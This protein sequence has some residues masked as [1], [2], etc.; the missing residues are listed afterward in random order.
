MTA[1]AVLLL[2]TSTEPLPTPCPSTG[3]ADMG[4]VPGGPFLRGVDPKNAG[5]GNRAATPSSTIWV[6]TF[7]MDRNEVTVADYRACMAEG[8]CPKAGPNY[9]DFDAPLQP[10]TGV[11]WFHAKQYCEA[12]GKRLPTEA[13]WEKAARGVD[14]RTFPWGDEPASC[15]RAV[16]MDER[17]R[18]CGIKQKSKKHADTGR[19]EPVG[20]RPAT[21]YGLFDM[22]GNSWEWVADWFSP[23]WKECGAACAGVDPKGPCG[24]AE[25]CPGHAER[26]VRG[27]S[28]YWPAEQMTTWH[29]RPH[30]P[31][32]RPVFHHFGFRCARAVDAR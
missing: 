3:P 30:T 7:W 21:Q 5:K 11:S 28:W 12:H 17:G 13:E 20:S 26:V 15:A 31:S 32:N 6:Q 14:G 22:A 29:R 24:G 18:S 8:R 2:L 1:L 10:I 9:Q 25:V 27:G 23:S 16:Y 19:P 4:C